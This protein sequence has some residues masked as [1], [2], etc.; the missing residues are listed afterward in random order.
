M[1]TILLEPQRRGQVPTTKLSCRAKRN[2][3]NDD[4]LLRHLK[5]RELRGSKIAN[6]LNRLIEV[7]AW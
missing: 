6:L 4:N 2:L 1:L 5:A 3:I 7:L